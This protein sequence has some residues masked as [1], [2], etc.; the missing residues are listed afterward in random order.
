[1]M[2]ER[3]EDRNE[4]ITRIYRVIQS[5]LTSQKNSVKCQTD[6]ACMNNAIMYD[7]YSY[8]VSSEDE[9]KVEEDDPRNNEFK[10]KKL[11][12]EIGVT[13]EESGDEGRLSSSS[14]K[15]AKITKED[16]DDD[17]DHDVVPELGGIISRSQL[18]KNDSAVSLLSKK[19]KKL[20]DGLTSQGS[21][22]KLRGSKKG[23][24]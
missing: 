6:E 14:R 3:L 4:Y 18:R 21:K 10:Y 22:S 23:R 16:I 13:L 5:M 15:P 17:E 1:M 8:G 19:S 7:Y 11:V 9:K 2:D 20:S 24:K 12:K